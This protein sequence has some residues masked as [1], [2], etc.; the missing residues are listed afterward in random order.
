MII[1]IF[2]IGIIATLVIP[3]I[4]GYLF[5]IT[6]MRILDGWMWI[7]LSSIIILGVWF[8][9]W[10]IYLVGLAFYNLFI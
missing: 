8:V 6:K 5:P 9:L 1:I 2:L 7:I 4:I 10:G 3:G